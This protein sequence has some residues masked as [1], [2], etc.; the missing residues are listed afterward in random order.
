M[1]PPA[2]IAQ[3]AFELADHTGHRER[4]K[5]RTL[6]RVVAVDGGDQPGPGGLAQIL[7]SRPAAVAIPASEP[8]GQ[9]QV[10]Q[11][12]LLS[13]HRIAAG[14]VLPQPPLDRGLGLLV[15]GADLEE[16][17][18]GKLGEGSGHRAPRWEWS[19]TRAGWTRQ[20]QQPS[21]LGLPC[22]DGSQT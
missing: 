1:Q 9:T 10:S 22:A 2:G 15:A 3:V 13:Q 11:D 6:G 4:D 12:D 14:G 20:D 18:V 8:V 16:G 19:S 7:R 21:N 5:R 17:M